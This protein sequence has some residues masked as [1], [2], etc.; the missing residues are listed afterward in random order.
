MSNKYEGLAPKICDL[1]GGVSNVL[2]VTHCATRLRLKLKDESLADDKAIED[3]PGVVSV[4]KSAGQYQVVIG[5]K[6]EVVY[7]DFVAIEGIKGE[8][9]VEATEEDGITA[10]EKGEKRGVGAVILDFISSM[11]GPMLGVICGAG[12]L[13]GVVSIIDATGL[14]AS[15]DTLYMVLSAAADAAYYFMPVLLGYTIAKKLKMSP[16]LGITLGA[17]LVYPDLQNMEN[18]FLFGIDVSG[19]TYKQTML[20]IVFVMLAAAPFDRFLKKHLPDSLMFLESAI[21]FAVMAPLA[22]AIIGPVMNLISTLIANGIQAVI[23]INPIIAGFLVC[24]LWQLLVLF[25]VHV[26]LAS[27]IFTLM[28]A[29]G[30]SML[31]P[32]TVIPAFAVFGVVLAIYLRTKDK[33]TKEVALPSA[34][35]AFVG[36]T[37][38]AIYGLLVS[39]VKSFSVVCLVSGLSGA[40]MVARG[41]TAYQMGG[42][43]IMA[44]LIA[45]NGSDFSGVISFAIAMAFATIAGFVVEFVLY[46][47]R[48]DEKAEVAAA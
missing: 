41:V 8:G 45:A 1:V 19:I 18:A 10:E 32:L 40:F 5:T 38:P 27:V 14:L 29:T 33:K 42:S 34:I 11:M 22:F 13:K 30:T 39:D 26:V 31:Y 36:V 9:A 35:S 48:K 17:I 4:V 43:S 28:F 20:P 6:V 24:G 21:L 37:E 15:T 46:R 47:N 23:D 16:V 12:V 44:L 2:A 7:D 3:L 25:G